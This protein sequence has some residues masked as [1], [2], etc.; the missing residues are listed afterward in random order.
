MGRLSRA[1]I[2]AMA[3]PLMTDPVFYAVTVP[4]ALMP[5][6]PVGVW[7]G[8]RLALRISPVWFYRMRYLGMYLTGVKLVWDG[9]N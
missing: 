1:T 5:L 4:A 7:I 2:C 9:F 3:R 8:V 6:A